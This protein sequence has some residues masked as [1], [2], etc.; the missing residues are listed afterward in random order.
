MRH[1]SHSLYSEP[2]SDLKD[3]SL[4]PKISVSRIIEEV[5]IQ[6][7][8]R[9]FPQAIEMAFTTRFTADEAFCFFLNKTKTCLYSSSLTRS[10]PFSESLVNDNYNDKKVTYYKCKVNNS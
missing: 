7:E 4:V 1:Y 9:P 6:S 2:L 8:M 10:C 5:V 3:V